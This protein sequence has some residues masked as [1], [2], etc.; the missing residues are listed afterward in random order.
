MAI[1]SPFL[2][3]LIT[4]SILRAVSGLHLQLNKLPVQLN[5][6]LSDLNVSLPTNDASALYLSSAP[7]FSSGFNFLS[8][9]TYTNNEPVCKGDLFGDRLNQAQCY[10][11]LRKIIPSPRALTFGD[12][13]HNFEVQLPRRYSSCKCL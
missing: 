10:D 13:G 7:A 9:A 6:S 4:P 1:L 8:A 12:R 2:I 5:I 11:A 3:P